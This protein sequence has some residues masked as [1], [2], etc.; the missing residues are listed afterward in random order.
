MPVYVYNRSEPTG[1]VTMTL[2]DTQGWLAGD[3]TFT[4]ALTETG[5]IVPVRVAVPGGTTLVTTDTV[6]V[7]AT[8]QADPTAT[9]SDTFQVRVAEVAD[10]SLEKS[11][12]G[13][14]H[15]G[16]PFTVTLVV[17]NDGPDDAAGVTVTDTLPSSAAFV[18]SEDC[19]SWADGFRCELGKL[20]SG[21][22]VTATAV[23]IAA[24][25][26][27]LHNRA[28][29][30]G[31]EH[32]RDSLDNA[33]S[34][35]TSIKALTPLREAPIEG[36]VEG[37]LDTTYAFT[38]TAAPLTATL[39]ITYT[40]EATGQDDWVIARY[41][42]SDTVQFNWGAGGNK[43]VTVT[44]ANEAGDAVVATDTVTIKQ[45]LYLPLVLR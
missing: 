22:Q 28:E 9:E 17:A 34:S 24:N 31:A 3:A 45:H 43:T 11:A 32:D 15:A 36:P 44:A 30:A 41:A 19:T 29:V 39:P 2:A 4:A 35:Y 12:P 14:V 7:T 1:V 23:L 33:D 6:T 18:S 10:L 27:V 8:S 21:A 20:A 40:W 26:G 25:E 13:R 37:E 38:A 16:A 42:I 5:V